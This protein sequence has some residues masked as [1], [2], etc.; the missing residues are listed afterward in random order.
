M[1]Y[2]L[3]F[4]GAGNMAEAIALAA[5]HGNIV[6][7]SSIV[8]ADPSEARRE[9][10]AS[11]GITTT[12]SNADVVN[13]SENILLAI[14]PQT[15]P[16]LG[17]QL[18]AI[19]TDKQVIISIMAGIRSAKIAEAAGKPIRVVRIMPNTPLMVG[20]GMAGVA[21]G[22]HAAPGDD[23]MA[24]RLFGAAGKAISVT[25]AELDAVTAVSGSGPAYVFYLAE[26][27]QKAASDLGLS[28]N[29]QLLVQQTVLGAAKLLSESE[30]SAEEL[31]RKVTSP[32]GTTAAAIEH[33]ETGKVGDTIAEA[34]RKAQARSI[35]LGK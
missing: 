9:L 3:G 22:E 32:G 21:L 29:G 2:E 6:S 4:V 8:A 19:D 26:A 31:R 23:A 14:K 28:E 30:D 10:F 1:K 27:M 35:E 18:S 25:E 7:A 11:H 15:L 5:I 13:Q 12:D 17:D 20:E 34:I 33:M 16:Q 24:M